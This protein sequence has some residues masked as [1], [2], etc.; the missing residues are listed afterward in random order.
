MIVTHAPDASP[1][2]HLFDTEFGPHAL[3]ADA[4]QVFA[5]DDE[6]REELK[7][8]AGLGPGAAREALGLPRALAAAME[9]PRLLGGLA[10]ACDAVYADLSAKHGA[11]AW[12]FYPPGVLGNRALTLP[13]RLHP[14]ARATGMIARHMLPAV[15]AALASGN[16]GQAAAA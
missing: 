8:A 4:S 3:L 6:T 11:A 7:R 12:P 14:N 13:D 15:T 5:L 1:Y 9:A 16:N 2:V 10:R